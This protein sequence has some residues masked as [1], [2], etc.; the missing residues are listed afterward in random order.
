VFDTYEHHWV[1]FK[2]SGANGEKAFTYI[3][4]STVA[5]YGNLQ[6]TSATLPGSLSVTYDH[7]KCV[8]TNVP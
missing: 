4:D 1:L 7:I 8:G 3:G 2:Q 5:N 6:F